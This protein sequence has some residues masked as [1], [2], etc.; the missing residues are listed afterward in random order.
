MFGD[1]AYS[2]ELESF[3]WCMYLLLCPPPGSAGLGVVNMVKSAMQRLLGGHSKE[4]HK[5]AIDQ[6]WILDKDVR[7]LAIFSKFCAG[8]KVLARP[9]V[10]SVLLISHPDG[11]QGV[12]MSIITIVNLA[13]VVAGINQLIFA[14]FNSIKL[15]LTSPL[16]CTGASDKSS[17]W[18]GRWCRAIC[19]GGRGVWRMR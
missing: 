3:F 17:R 4:T 18:F 14:C 9:T 6:F 10:I 19:S 12:W 15:I 7:Y 8:M 2:C 5:K 1:L 13:F 11:E 16:K